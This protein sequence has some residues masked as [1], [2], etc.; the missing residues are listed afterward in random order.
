MVRAHL[1][2]ARA[3]LTIECRLAQLRV[4]TLFRDQCELLPQTLA[5]SLA[6]DVLS[7]WAGFGGFCREV[8]GVEPLIIV[9]AFELEHIDPES[10]VRVIFP[11]S[12]ADRASAANWA[13]RWTRIWERRFADGSRL[14]RNHK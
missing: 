3:W 9:R 2:V 4:L 8:L 10:Q 11:Q 6:A 12:T 5:E 7:Q 1:I 13:Q 14:Q